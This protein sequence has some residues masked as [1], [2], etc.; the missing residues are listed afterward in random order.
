M[1]DVSAELQPNFSVWRQTSGNLITVSFD[2]LAWLLVDRE[3]GQWIP[4]TP[5]EQM[6]GAGFRVGHVVE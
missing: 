4:D 3:G 6:K 5:G 1:A 2:R